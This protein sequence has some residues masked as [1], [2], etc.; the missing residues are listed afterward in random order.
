MGEG[1]Y[2]LARVRRSFRPCFINDVVIYVDV[3][4]YRYYL[5]RS[6]NS[7]VF[8]RGRPIFICFIRTKFLGRLLGVFFVPGSEVLGTNVCGYVAVSFRATICRF[9]C[10]SSLFLKC[11]TRVDFRRLFTCRFLCFKRECED[12]VL[13]AYS[14]RFFDYLLGF[15]FVFLLW[16]H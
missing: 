7:E 1:A 15:F 11:V 6:I 5:R 13:F 4:R 3:V 10:T 14:L 12:R 8:R 16:Y 9:R 2:F